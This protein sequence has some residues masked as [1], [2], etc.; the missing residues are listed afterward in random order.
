MFQRIYLTLPLV[1][2]ALILAG[3]ALGQFDKVTKVYLETSML[4]IHGNAQKG[5]TPQRAAF[6]NP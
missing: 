6:A 2:L 1:S 4:R 3:Y 5:V